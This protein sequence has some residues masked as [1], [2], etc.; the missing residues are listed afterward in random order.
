MVR[1]GQDVVRV[2]LWRIE[3]PSL[4]ALLGPSGAG[5][6]TLLHGLAGFLPWASA[7]AAPQL[8]VA[9]TPLL[10]ALEP[11][12]TRMR[13]TH[14]GIMEQ[15]LG[16]LPHL[17]AERNVMA[18]ALLGG[19]PPGDA[20]ARAHVML[21]RLA[22]LDKRKHPAGALSRGQQQ[23]LALARVLLHP[24][25]LLLLDEPDASLDARSVDVLLTLLRERVAGGAIIVYATHDPGVAQAADASLRI[26]NGV[27]EPSMPLTSPARSGEET[28][29]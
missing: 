6:S 28:R 9:G 10:G 18:S 2:P 13:Q 21:E 1:A 5:K 3:R 11:T 12:W 27:L 25:A 23:K 14:I 16:I 15:H 19:L 22:L 24:G 20:L 4:V 7:G 17:S 8:V 29:G 26:Q